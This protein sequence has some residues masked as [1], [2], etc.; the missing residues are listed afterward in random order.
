[1]SKYSNYWEEKKPRKQ[2]EP[3]PIW[4]G[5]GFLMLIIVP[6]MSWAAATLLL[7]ENSKQHWVYFERSMI[8][9]GPYP[10]LYIQI[11]LT[12]ILSIFVFALIY[13]VYFTIY[14]FTG[15][16]RYG[17]MDVPRGNERVK[18]YKR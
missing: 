12:I 3:H 1:M 10:L 5:I 6:F 14:R 8:A 18:K 9:P 4:R 2:K 16:S 13:F 11:F 17:P 15:P 7:D